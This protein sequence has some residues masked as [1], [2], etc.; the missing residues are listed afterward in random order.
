MVGNFPHNAQPGD[1]VRLVRDDNAN[2]ARGFSIFVYAGDVKLGAVP[3]IDGLDVRV[4]ES[5]RNYVVVDCEITRFLKGSYRTPIIGDADRMRAQVQELTQRLQTCTGVESVTR[6]ETINS[7]LLGLYPEVRAAIRARRAALVNSLEEEQRAIRETEARVV[8]SINE[9]TTQ[10]ELAAVL[11][12]APANVRLRHAVTHAAIRR[13]EV[14]MAEEDRRRAA[15]RPIVARAPDLIATI[16][17]SWDVSL[18]RFMM[19]SDLEDA[20]TEAAA[21]RLEELT[22]GPR[23]PVVRPRTVAVPQAPAAKAP[24]VSV[25]APTRRIIL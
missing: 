1:R 20:V 10:E 14:F 23:T 4:W 6:L 22:Q 18:L 16:R 15:S 17:M 13:R 21:R 7:T 25:E 11:A 3:Y 2:N 24:K 8:T 9:A 5:N 19:N 12:A